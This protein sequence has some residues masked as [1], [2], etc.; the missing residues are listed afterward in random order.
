VATRRPETKT[1]PAELVLTRVFDAPRQLVFETWSTPEHLARWWG[2]KGFTLPFCEM[3][4]KPNGA[5]RYTMRGPDGRDYGCKGVYLEVVPHERI[6]MTGK[7]DHSDED[8]EILTTVTF[9]EQA[10]KTKLT[11]RQSYSR[12]TDATRGA[13]AGWT[14]TLE[15]LAEYLAKGGK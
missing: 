14:Q 11:V 6:V 8:L 13:N 5:Y 2:P 1:A 10:G 9:A 12:E 4:F 7:L 3:S 15:R